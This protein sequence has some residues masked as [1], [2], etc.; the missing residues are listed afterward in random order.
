MGAAG[1]IAHCPTDKVEWLRTLGFGAPI[2]QITDPEA[3]KRAVLVM[4][5]DGDARGRSED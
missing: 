4:D 2:G 5:L 1:L 3:G